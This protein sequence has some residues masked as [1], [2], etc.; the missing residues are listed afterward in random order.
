MKTLVTCLLSCAALTA[1]GTSPPAARAASQPPNLSATL[2]AGH[3]DPTARAEVDVV[4]VDPTAVA[5]RLRNTSTPW[6]QGPRLER[7]AFS[8][9]NDPGLSCLAFHDA[10]NR[11]TLAA[12]AA[13]L[14]G[15]VHTFAYELSALTSPLWPTE[16]LQVILR[17][18]P[19]CQSHFSFTAQTFLG[20]TP[21][22]SGTQ[23]AQLGAALSNVEGK[24]HLVCVAGSLVNLTPGVH[25]S[26]ATF[27]VGAAEVRTSTSVYGPGDSRAGSVSIDLA[28]DSLL[29]GITTDPPLEAA[30]L[31]LRNGAGVILEQQHLNRHWVPGALDE[32]GCTTT[33]APAC[34]VS[35]PDDGANELLVAAVPTLV[36]DSNADFDLD[37]YRVTVA[38]ELSLDYT[39]EPFLDSG[40]EVI[41]I[42]WARQGSLRMAQLQL[43]AAY[44]A[45]L[46]GSSA[47]EPLVTLFARN[48]PDHPN[49]ASSPSVHVVTATETHLVID[50]DVQAA[51]ESVRAA[52]LTLGV[53]DP[54][55]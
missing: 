16:E 9:A 14:C 10:S 29:D 33:G 30:V 13:P 38:A 40:H 5:L 7:V 51:L 52:Y 50:V 45:N 12:P 22:Q 27:L 8:L 42:T 32:G 49:G 17:V 15:G 20:S 31:T 46:D 1:L 44:D 35:W 28:G 2:T 19:A 18:K 53:L 23:T 21:A 48:A 43:R 26:W 55:Q 24:D 11:F 37:G 25:F 47:D 4:L 54:P 41:R 36:T 39:M 34:F 6:Q 3:L